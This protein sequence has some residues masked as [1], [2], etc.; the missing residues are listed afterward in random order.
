MIKTVEKVLSYNG[1][2]QI[3]RS[4]N[5]SVTFIDFSKIEYEY[6]SNKNWC[7][8]IQ[9]QSK[10]VFAVASRGDKSSRDRE[11][12]YRAISQRMGLREVMLC[13]A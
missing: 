13:E 9:N 3:Y 2:N 12:I 10:G 6:K 7:I 5:D 8:C 11:D 4:G 1:G